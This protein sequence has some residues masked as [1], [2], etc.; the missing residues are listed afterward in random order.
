MRRAK[1]TATVALTVSEN[2]RLLFLLVAAMVSALSFPAAAAC[3]REGCTEAA[4]TATS[5]TVPPSAQAPAVQI[6]ELPGQVVPAT[7]S[8]GR[9]AGALVMRP[10]TVRSG[11]RPSPGEH[12]RSEPPPASGSEPAPVWLMLFAGLAFAGVVVAKRSRG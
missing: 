9:P 10:E 5:G 3:E 11:A 12:V 4:P 7:L 6:A 2:M 8:D 1:N